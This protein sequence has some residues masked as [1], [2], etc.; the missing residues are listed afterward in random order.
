[1][2]LGV[3]ARFTAKFDRALKQKKRR[4]QKLA[5]AVYETVD[6][7]L[8][9]PDSVGLNA[10]LVDREKRIWEAYVNKDT[11]ITYQRE[12]D[13]IIFRNNCRHDIIDRR[14]W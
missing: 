3:E 4:Q 10:H 8:R 7:L 9:E 5:I 1:M 11:R 14:Q 13:T 12:G 2:R 6:R